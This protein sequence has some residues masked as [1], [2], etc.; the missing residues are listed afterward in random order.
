MVIT[1]IPTYNDTQNGP[2]TTRLKITVDLS[3][4]FSLL[5]QYNL[6]LKTQ[7]AVTTL[8]PDATS[9]VIMS[10]AFSEV[11][12][13]IPAPTLSFEA[14]ILGDIQHTSSIQG[15]AEGVLLSKFS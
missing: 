9:P 4:I 10:Y 12:R 13:N 7:L 3:S 8:L 1:I 5:T 6:L 15:T 2:P 11:Y 14:I